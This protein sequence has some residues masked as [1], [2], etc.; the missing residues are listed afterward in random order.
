MS[1]TSQEIKPEIFADV[2]R[3]AQELKVLGRHC[4]PM[5]KAEQEA[6]SDGNTIVVKGR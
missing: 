2:Q 6:D 3:L 5:K 4:K 1:E